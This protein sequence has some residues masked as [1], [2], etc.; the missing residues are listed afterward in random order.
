MRPAP[1]KPLQARESAAHLQSANKGWNE[2]CLG[3]VL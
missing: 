2:E 1:S 3:A